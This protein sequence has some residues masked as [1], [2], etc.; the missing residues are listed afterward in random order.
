M[1]WFTL[2]PPRLV[3]RLCPAALLCARARPFVRACVHGESDAIAFASLSFSRHA[4]S[5]V[6]NIDHSEP[7]LENTTMW[8]P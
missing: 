7:Y 2:P 6:R 1:F 4:R 5:L 8:A 3:G